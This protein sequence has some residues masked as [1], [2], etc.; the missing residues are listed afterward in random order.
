MTNHPDYVHIKIKKYR[1]HWSQHPLKTQAWYE[2]Q[3]ATRTK[4]EVAQE[5][6]ISYD[7]SVA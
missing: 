4:L 5:L 3:K 1:L 7:N 2:R 6:D